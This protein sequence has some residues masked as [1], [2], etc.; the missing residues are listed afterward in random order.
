MTLGAFTYTDA[1]ALDSVTNVAGNLEQELHWKQLPA[2]SAVLWGTQEQHQTPVYRCRPSPYLQQTS[3]QYIRRQYVL[4]H[5]AHVRHLINQR[6]CTVDT[7]RQPNA[8][9]GIRGFNQEATLI[10]RYLD[11]PI[12]QVVSQHLAFRVAR[13]D[14]VEVGNLAAASLIHSGRLIV[15]LLHLLAS[16]KLPYAVCTGTAAVRLALKRTGVPFD[17]IGD[18][19]PARLGVEHLDWGSYYDKAPQILLI[20]IEQGMAA[21]AKRYQCNLLTTESVL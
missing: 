1:Q 3:A 15:F 12:E 17:Y 5:N 13:S 8:V 4:S 16:Q 7:N 20:D 2:P 6:F 9:V 10:E 19:D 14:L 11:A 18:A 21:I